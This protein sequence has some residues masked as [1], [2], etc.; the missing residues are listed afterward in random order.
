MTYTV[1]S[2]I[3][4]NT[5]NSNDDPGLFPAKL[6]YLVLPGASAPAPSAQISAA[7]GNATDG[8]DVLSGANTND[9]LDGGDGNDRLF[10]LGGNDYLI[11]GSGADALDG[12]AGLDLA[13]YTG[14]ARA[15]NVSLAYGAGYT[16]DARG[17]TLIGIEDL[18]GSAFG[19]WLRG[20]INANWLDGD[21][22]NDTIEG[23]GGADRLL[24]GAGADV[25]HGDGGN[26]IL[27]GGTGADALEGGAGIDTASY[28]GSAT[29]VNV[30]LAL[31]KGFSGDASGDKLYGIENLAGS[32]LG[33]WLRGSAVANV[34]DGGDGNDT[35]EGGGGTDRLLGG[36]GA[37]VLHG[38]DGY[39]LLLGGAGADALEGGAGYD[40]A[41][42]VDASGGVWIDLRTGVGHSF[43]AEGDRLFGIEKV[44]GGNFDDLLISSSGGSALSGGGG[45]DHLSGSRGG[46]DRLDGGAGADGLYGWEGNDTVV[47][48]SAATGVTVSLLNESLNTGEAGGDHY[49]GVENIV[50]SA[51][52][53]TL[54][55]DTGG[56][57]LDGIEGNDKLDGGAGTDTL[58]GGAGADTFVFSSSGDT[59][60][61]AAAD[62]ITDFSKSQGDKIDLS[63][64]T[65]GAGGFIGSAAFG[66]HAN[67]V[68]AETGGG[69][70]NV[71]IDVDGDGT[72]DAQIRLTGA[73]SLAT[74]DFS[75]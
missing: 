49:A 37:D 64:I 69:A 30:S 15:V 59:G 58:T 55:G 21:A 4:E 71:Y 13:S 72:A 16:G 1:K 60:L 65:G 12:G 25:L 22:G 24:G 53:D 3:D 29:P 20:N 39:D 8:D 74:G 51:F 38:G 46:D 63:G 9:V 68:R 45:N 17:D 14:S 52:A 62:R 47:Y 31:G 35:I 43:E 56:N 6:A 23:G 61:G 57:R 66:H 28:S 54:I 75:L 19:D 5:E 18:R 67:E 50:G 41:N 73:I 10:G 2:L 40:T 33:D 44:V 48:D 26:D 7:L 27:V 42:Y 70:T 34:L 11:G 36:A 32:A